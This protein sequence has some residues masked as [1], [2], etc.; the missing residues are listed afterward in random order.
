MK[1]TQPGL[2]LG[3][4]FCFEMASHLSCNKKELTSGLLP[5]ASFFFTALEHTIKDWGK[6]YLFQ[7]Q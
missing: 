3:E 1:P 6:S 7:G 2:W 5:Q 4:I